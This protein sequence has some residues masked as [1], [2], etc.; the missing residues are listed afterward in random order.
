MSRGSPD[1]NQALS[2]GVSFQTDPL[3]E[4]LL[5]YAK[6]LLPKDKVIAPALSMVSR[7]REPDAPA[8]SIPTHYRPSKEDDRLIRQAAEAGFGRQIDE[9]TAGNYSSD[10][11][12]LAAAL[13]PLSISK[14]GHDTLL[15]HA[16]TLFPGNKK[17]IY[18]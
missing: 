17:L 5:D 8:R 12:K 16:D 3:P 7:Y 18:A 6:K 4:S 11:R 1:V 15:G 9:K 10:L 14:L 13:R 2:F